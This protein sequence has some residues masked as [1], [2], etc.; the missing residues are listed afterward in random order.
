MSL[1][2]GGSKTNT[3]GSSNTT[4]SSTTTPV[5]P[6][7]AS[8]LTQNVSGR[9]GSLLDNNPQSLVAPPDP[10]QNLAA[11]NA[12]NLSGTPWDYDAAEQ[13]SGAVA[14]T[15]TPNI[16]DYIGRFMDPY[17]KNVVNAT[18]ADLDANDG[19]V[20]AQQALDLAGSG[21]FGGS[22]AALTQSAT[23]GEL[24]RARATTL[25][26]L[27]SQGYAQALG[28]ATS[29]A[30][31]QQ[32]QENQRLAAAQQMA[33]IAGAYGANQRANVATQTA[34]GDDLRNIAQ[35]QAQAPV[36]STAQIVAMLSGLPINLF[37]GQTSDGTSNTMQKGQVTGVNASFDSGDALSKIF[38]FG[39]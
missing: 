2:I 23:E 34:T 18:S 5:V 8:S 15:D 9:V 10:L 28:G 30:Q 24:A 3:S 35:Q 4:T 39:S 29:Q 32:Q 13:L 20:R 38:K 1:K 31:L 17:L 27:R 19:R 6:D 16:A 25:G 33:N 7:W 11:G 26:T 22:G 12:T 36:T 37:T 14:N 21:A